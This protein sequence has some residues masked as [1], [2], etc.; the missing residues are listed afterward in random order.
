MI[1]PLTANKKLYISI[2]IPVPN[3]PGSKGLKL[4]PVRKRTKGLK[5]KTI[6]PAQILF[7][8]FFPDILK[9]MRFVRHKAITI[10]KTSITSIKTTPFYPNISMGNSTILYILF[11]NMVILLNKGKVPKASFGNISCHSEQV[12]RT[13]LFKINFHTVSEP[14]FL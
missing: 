4:I 6:I 5:S 10:I 12:D 8:L 3:P 14:Y 2:H 9:A 11:N 1:I 7:F 13:V